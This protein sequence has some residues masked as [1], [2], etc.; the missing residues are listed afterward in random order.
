[1]LALTSISVKRCFVF[2]FLGKIV[3][4]G[5]F[6]RGNGKYLAPLVRPDGPAPKGLESL[7]QGL[8]WVSRFKRFALKGQ[9]LRT[10]SGSKVRSRF[11]PYL[12]ASSGLVTS[13]S[14]SSS[15]FVLGW[16]RFARMKDG[17]IC[18][19]REDCLY[20]PTK[21]R[22]RTTTRTRRIQ[23]CKFRSPHA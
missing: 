16:R 9:E 22:P 5:N 18:N 21:K 23:I 12:V 8:P 2:I 7:A 14:S 11:S 3:V 13:R 15:F 6:K 1:M 10:R 20:Q 4:L 19:W 17:L